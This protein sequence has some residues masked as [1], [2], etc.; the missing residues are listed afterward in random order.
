MGEYRMLDPGERLEPGDEFLR[1]PGEWVVLHTGIFE[2]LIKA[3][4]YEEGD[5]PVR[6][7][8]KEDKEDD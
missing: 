7:E 2:G 3:F 5:L 8:L 4:S 6:R 1:K